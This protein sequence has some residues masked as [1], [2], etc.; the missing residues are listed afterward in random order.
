LGDETRRCQLNRFPYG[1]VYA[2]EDD[3]VVVLAVMFLRRKPGYWRD[4]LKR[5]E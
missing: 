2:V 4:R 5:R 3:A 1:L